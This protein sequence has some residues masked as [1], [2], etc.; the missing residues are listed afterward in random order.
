MNKL[1]M[2]IMVIGI[3]ALFLGAG[4]F[5]YFSDTETSTNNTFTAGTLD[6][7]ITDNTPITLTNMKPGD[8]ATGSMTV[9]NIGGL[10]GCL[11]ATSWYVTADGIPNPY[12][13]MTDDEVAKM[14]LITAFTADTVD[15]L[16]KIPEVDGN[17]G[18]SVYDLVNDPSGND[19]AYSPPGGYPASPG[20]LNTWYSYDTDMTADPSE[21]HIYSLTILFDTAAGNDYQGDGITLTF[22]FLLT[23]Q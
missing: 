1:L 21:S 18:K 3:A 9:E 19:P 14:L 8:S 13:D 16:F 17:P 12:A 11:Y 23:Q 6:L 4:T 10:P 15:I 22:E 20:Q 7:D 2:S 5:A